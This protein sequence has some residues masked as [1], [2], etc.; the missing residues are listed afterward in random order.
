[1]RKSQNGITLIGWV[2]L[3][4]PLAIVGFA[5]LRLTPIYLNYMKVA[6]SMDRIAKDGSIP[7]DTAPNPTA[8]KFAIEKYLDIESVD[9]PKAE[10]IHLVREGD[11]WAEVVD[12]T[13]SVEMFANISLS[14]HF[15][16][17]VTLK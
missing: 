8:F 14:V 1:M 15:H 3:L 13:D 10:D 5:G 2:I 12:Y 9:T 7:T 4:T 11:S 6:R 17:S 16:K